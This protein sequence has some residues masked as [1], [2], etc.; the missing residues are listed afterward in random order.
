MS[1]DDAQQSPP[2]LIGSAD[3]CAL[4]GIER[5]T[6]IRWVQLGQVKYTIKM[7][8]KSGAYLFDPEYIARLVEAQNAEQRAEQWRNLPA[9]TDPAD[10]RAP[11]HKN[12]S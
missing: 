2:E 6:L 12:A 4:L 5:S 11:G 10:P 1:N 7:P 9:Y 8:G 3:V